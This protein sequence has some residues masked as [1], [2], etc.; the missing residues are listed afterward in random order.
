MQEV[1]EVVPELT[2]LQPEFGMIPARIVYLSFYSETV[3]LCYG[4][5]LT[6]T[7]LEKGFQ[8]FKTRG[9]PDET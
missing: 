2:R 1:K 4:I 6:G 9:E 7:V 8:M 5:V 3:F